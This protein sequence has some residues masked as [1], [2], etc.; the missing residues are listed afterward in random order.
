MPADQSDWLNIDMKA[1]R[2]L[3]LLAEHALE[4]LPSLLI[5][6]ELVSRL[7]LKRHRRG[8]LIAFQTMLR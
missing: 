1:D 5:L 2:A 4:L 7:T 3:E 8:T 6:P